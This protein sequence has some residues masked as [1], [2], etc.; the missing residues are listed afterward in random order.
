VGFGWAVGGV[1]GNGPNA[2]FV[3]IAELRSFGQSISSLTNISGAPQIV[4]DV[5]PSSQ[6]L[7]AGGPL[8]YNVVATGTQPLNYQ[9]QFNGANLGDNGRLSGSHASVLNFVESLP[10][11]SGG[12]RVIVSNGQGSVTSSVAN[13]TL[14]RVALNDG[15]GWANNGN[16]VIATNT[17]TLTDGATGEDSSSFLNFPLYI[18]AFTA[19]WT[20]QDV[21]GGGA[22]GTVFV[23]QNDS[24]GTSALGGGGG[25]L[26]YSGITPS[27][28]LE[29][30][31]YGPNTP[32]MAF[33]ANGVTGTPYAPTAPLN[34]AS[35]DP[36]GVTVHYDGTTVSLT[37]TDAVAHTSFRT[38]LV[39][40]IPSV[41]GTNVAFVG[42]TGASGGVAS[43]QQVSN[44]SFYN[45]PPLVT[46]LTGGNTLVLSWPASSVGFELQQTSALGTSWTPVANTVDL[47]GGQNQVTISPLP[48]TRFYRLVLP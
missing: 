13:V 1:Q 31:V 17:V 44:F 28:G 38:N 15:R 29:F 8:A 27:V 14:T 33:R 26:G 6:T 35:G 30:N 37:L 19:T 10:S 20:Y 48:G 9:W 34:V 43:Y 24:R 46:R 4:M 21:G 7:P 36:I 16:A 2:Q 25:G 32:G 12:Y 39:V 23:L 41:V 11:D 45:P 18:G 47:V 3:S 22:D 40:D 42:F 5:A